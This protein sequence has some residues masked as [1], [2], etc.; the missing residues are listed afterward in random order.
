MRK[1]RFGLTVRKTVFTLTVILVNK[2]LHCKVLRDRK[3][4]LW[5]NEWLPFPVCEKGKTL[6]D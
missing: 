4:E 2:N 3:S 5:E 1:L 6:Q